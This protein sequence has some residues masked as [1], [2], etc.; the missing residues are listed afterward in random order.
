MSIHECKRCGVDQERRAKTAKVV[1]ML[2]GM[3]AESGEGFN[4]GVPVMEAVDVLVHGRDV[5]KSEAIRVIKWLE[6]LEARHLCAK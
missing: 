5:D 2:Q 3:H 1:E 4:V 6:W